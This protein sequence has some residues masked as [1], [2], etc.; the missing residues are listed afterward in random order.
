[1]VKNERKGFRSWAGRLDQILRAN[2]SVAITGW[3]PSIRICLWPLPSGS[4][5]N[6]GG[7]KAN[8]KTHLGMAA[9]GRKQ[10]DDK[11]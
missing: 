2:C 6:P 4:A 1:M 3:R 7:V 8:Q 5:K 9:I 11:A 10:L